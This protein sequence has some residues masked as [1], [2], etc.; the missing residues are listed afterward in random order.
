MRIHSSAY[1]AE[2][3]L[4]FGEVSI[5][6]PETVKDTLGIPKEISF[7]VAIN[8]EDISI[9]RYEEK[10][11]RIRYKTTQPFGY[12]ILGRGR[13][14]I[15]QDADYYIECFAPA[16]DDRPVIVRCDGKSYD[17]HARWI[18]DRHNLIATEKTP[19]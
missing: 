6:I 8:K 19:F 5:P 2:F 13:A 9:K 14:K 17:G 3:S 1:D 15:D 12:R 11:E 7:W 10:N 4:S 16:A 18:V